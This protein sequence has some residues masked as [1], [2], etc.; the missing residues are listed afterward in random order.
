MWDDEC[1]ENEDDVEETEPEVT[2]DP[3]DDQRNED[4]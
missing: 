1:T 4:Y 3:R 2:S